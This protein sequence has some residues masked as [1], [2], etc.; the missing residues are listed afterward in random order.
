MAEFDQ[1]AE[2]Y[3]AILERSTAIGGETSEYFTN[4]KAEYV[5][6]V[7]D[8]APE[9]AMGEKILDYGCGIGA[10]SAA[11]A[12]RLP[13]ATIH[14]FDVSESSLRQVQPDV[15]AKGI[16]TAE[17]QRL[18]ADYALIVIS[19]V[20]HHIAMA[21]RQW[22][23]KELAQR[24]A[25]GGRILIFEHNPINPLTRLVVARCPFDENAVLLRPAEIRGYFDKAGLT[26]LRRDYVVFF[27]RALKMLRR[28]EPRLRWC[29]AGAQYALVGAKTR[30]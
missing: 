16:F 12:R 10:L 17:W 3:K 15:L 9:R 8:E 5:G 2:D 1:F 19:N 20:L 26:V 29:P 6:R 22:T 18:S 24:L 21:E 13:G 30:E 25:P 11:L 7:M 27:P 23:I 4:Y 14:G 28:L